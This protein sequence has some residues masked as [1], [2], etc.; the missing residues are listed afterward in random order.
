M[1]PA[2]D[3]AAPDEEVPVSDDSPFIE[4]TDEFALL[5]GQAAERGIDGP[6]PRGR[7]V[8]V[9][10]G[11]GSSEQA[12]VS[13]LLWG[14]DPRVTLLH[15]AGLNAHTWD[16]TVA[17]LGID[18]L[19]LDLPGHGDSSWRADAD[20]RPQTIA[21]AVAEALRSLTDRPQVVVG[22]SL[23]GLVGAM[24]A[25]TEP[26][27]VAALMLVDITPGV[28]PAAGPAQVRAFFAGPTDWASR[29]EL[30]DRA[31][32]FGLGGGSRRRAARGVYFNSR[33]R[34]DGRVEWKHHFGRLAA[35]A[36]AASAAEGSPAEG[37][38][39]APPTR[40]AL[41]SHEGWS[42]LSGIADA[43]PIELVRATRGFV[44]TADADELTRRLPRASVVD[45]DAGHNVQEDAPVALAA[46]IGALAHRV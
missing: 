42:A 33:V 16:T 38:D 7:R 43:T 1:D 27:L 21:P 28:D 13:G 45:I 30:V 39:E 17:A 12:S 14:E 5:A 3:G 4:P 32:Q 36:A 44:T 34:P 40:G 19:A 46:T 29:D 25:A 2:R 6:L 10:V 35:E 41:V 31:L 11:A 20:Y 23:G 22:H 37:H 26:D 18:A 8:T 9:A 15:G 24:L